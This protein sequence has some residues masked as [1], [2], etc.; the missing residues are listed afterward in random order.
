MSSHL[1]FNMSIK[2]LFQQLNG[3]KLKVEK[4]TKPSY[5]HI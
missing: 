3:D 5:H 4:H 1:Q 2:A